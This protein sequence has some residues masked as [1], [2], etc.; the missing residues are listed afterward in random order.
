MKKA[1]QIAQIV[2]RTPRTTLDELPEDL[3]Y[4]LSGIDGQALEQLVSDDTAWQLA[5][6]AQQLEA[7]GAILR[8]YALD[9]LRRSLPPMKFSAGLAER[10]IA[11][12]TAYDA[13]DAF[14]L[15]KRFG[16]LGVVPALAQLGVS[17][18]LAL[19]SWSD[20]Q[21]REFAD[22]EPV[23]GLTL[24][25][26]VD[27]S[28][29]DIQDHQREW[30]QD[31]DQELKKRD[32]AIATLQTQL[33]TLKTENLRLVRN[34]AGLQTEEDLPHFALVIRQEAMALTEAMSFCLDSLQ[35]TL[36]EHLFGE[37]KLPDNQ[38]R[39]KA[40]AA[41]TAYY[42]L[43]SI[44]ARAQHLLQRISEQYGAD[45]DDMIKLEHQLSPSELK[46][47]IETRE[48]ILIAHQSEAKRRE[49]ERE[50]NRPGKR[51]AK[52]KGGK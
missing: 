3:Q 12:R 1:N 24:D 35:A 32:G 37:T 30:Q 17:K 4:F 25:Q 20:E 29:R 15:Y 39:F 38:A 19:K 36:D 23:K 44:H 5:E 10:H 51:G 41:G 18:T 22:G 49:D 6:A 11:R 9:H 21:I 52:R 43:G 48:Q 33:E 16:E 45:I 40:V 8:G 31:H 27:M 2:V 46:R 14:S 34:G 50:N 13:I 47:F 7:R 28:A 26:V 42:A